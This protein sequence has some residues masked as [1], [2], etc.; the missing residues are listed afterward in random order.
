MKKKTILFLLIIQ[1]TYSIG[2][3][4]Q[5]TQKLNNG[6][7]VRTSKTMQLASSVSIA[8]F[9]KSNKIE[10]FNSNDELKDKTIYTIDGM[11]LIYKK[12]YKNEKIDLVKMKLGSDR[13]AASMDVKK[14]TTIV[15]DHGYKMLVSESNAGNKY[16]FLIINDSTKLNIAG[17]LQFNSSKKPEA[18]IVMDEI[19]KTIIIE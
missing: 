5:K 8:S 7:N 10:L 18:K 3:M 2:L 11:I 15:E 14:N 6:I 9:A 19:I 16:Q 13:L 12:T 17:S 4:A 1:L